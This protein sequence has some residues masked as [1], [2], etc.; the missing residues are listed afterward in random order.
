MG[1]AGRHQDDLHG[2]NTQIEF[3]LREAVRGR[4]G[5][6]SLCNPASPCFANRVRHV[7]TVERLTR[8]RRATALP[9]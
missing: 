4:R 5:L 7:D 2:V 8:Y 3:L 6:I 1:K 9:L